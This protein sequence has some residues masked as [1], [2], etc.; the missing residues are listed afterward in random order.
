M[1]PKKKRPRCSYYEGNRRCIKSGSGNPPLC[2][3]HRL[4]LEDDEDEEY[5]D[6]LDEILRRHPRSGRPR[7]RPLQASALG[8]IIAI[9]AF[10][11]T[12]GWAP[13]S[14]TTRATPATAAQ[15]DPGGSIGSFGVSRGEQAHEKTGQRPPEEAR[16]DFPPRYGWFDPGYAEAQRRRR[17]IARKSI[18]LAFDIYWRSPVGRATDVAANIQ[19]ARDTYT[20]YRSWLRRYHGGAPVGFLA[21]IIE[22]ESGGSMNSKGDPS[23]GEVGLFQITSS[24]PPSVGVPAGARY[25]TETNIFLGCLEYQIEAASLSAWAPRLVGTGTADSWLLARLAFSI[26][27]PGTR[28][29][30]KRATNMSPIHAGSVYRAVKNH[31]NSGGAV[32][33]GRQ[34]PEKVQKR[35][36]DAQIL[37]D[38]GSKVAPTFVGPPEKIPSPSGVNYTLPSNVARYFTSWTKTFIA[39]GAVVGAVVLANRF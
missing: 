7:R 25:D 13:A 11:A 34:S 1:P 20:K 33:L 22:H 35:V 31:V 2:K 29:L 16:G 3:P 28:T 14:E 30:I 24:F 17:E 39:A 4:V 23:L 37:W 27:G 9:A 38:I 15:S 19:N 26:G 6:P 18:D 32:S 12:E 10:T 5:G 8:A 21:A 36:N